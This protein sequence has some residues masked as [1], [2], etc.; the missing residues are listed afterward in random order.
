MGSGRDALLALV[1][2]EHIAPE[3]LSESPRVAAVIEDIESLNKRAR[4][5]GLRELRGRL[6]G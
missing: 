1:K 2:A 5:P 6:Y 4:L 3:E